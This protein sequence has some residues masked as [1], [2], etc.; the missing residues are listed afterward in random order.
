MDVPRLE[1]HQDPPQ[2]GDA[3]ASS[4]G[5]FDDLMS[6]NFS[7][8]AVSTG[9]TLEGLAGLQTPE[10]GINPLEQ[11]SSSIATATAGVSEIP[12]IADPSLPSAS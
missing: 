3:P 7:Q 11:S 8:P 6:L 4:S 10:S 2:A 1:P 9:I 5:T 12:T